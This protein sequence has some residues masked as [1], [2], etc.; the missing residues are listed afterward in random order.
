MK[1]LKRKVI[2]LVGVIAWFWL[3][4]SFAVDIRQLKTD[5]SNMIQHFEKIK[6]VSSENQTAN[7][8][9]QYVWWGLL[10]IDTDNII[11]SNIINTTPVKIGGWKWSSIL[12]GIVNEIE[13]NVY[14]VI[15][16][17]ENNSISTNYSTIIWWRE[18]TVD[19][20]QYGTILWW[21]ENVLKGNF[22]TIVWGSNNE[23]I[24]EKSVSLWKNG[25]VS[26]NNSVWIWSDFEV[27][28]KNSFVW[29]AGVDNIE[30]GENV[31]VVNGGNGMVINTGKAYS[32]AKLTV[33]W[34]MIIG[35]NNISFTSLKCS[36]DTRWALIIKKNDAWVRCFCTCNGEERNSIIWWQC[37]WVCSKKIVPECG[38]EVHK[39]VGS[40]PPYS[41]S[42]S[43]EKWEVVEW[44]WAYVVWKNDI[45]YWSCQSVDWVVT[46]CAWVLPEEERLTWDDRSFEC[47][48]KMS[49]REGVITWWGAPSNGATWY[50]HDESLTKPCSYKC[51]EVWYVHYDWACK[52]KAKG[53][54]N[55]DVKWWCESWHPGNQDE[56]IIDR[57]QWD[58]LGFWM[59]DAFWCRKCKE[60]Y[61]LSGDDCV[62]RATFRE[63][64]GDY[65]KIIAGGKKIEVFAE[66][67]PMY[68]WEYTYNISDD[69][70]IMIEAW[71]HEPDKAVYYMLRDVDEIYLPKN[72]SNM[73]ASMKDLERI[74]VE[75]D[76]NTSKVMNM[77]NMFAG[78]SQLESVDVSNWDTSNVTNMSNMFKNCSS[79][80]ELDLSSWNTS[81]VT[82]MES[83][84]K[85]CSSLTELDLSSWN[86]SNV[87]NMYNMFNDCNNLI[88]IYGSCW[89]KTSAIAD[90]VTMFKNC[91]NL[92]WWW[93]TTY[94]S[95]SCSSN[96][97]HT[98][99]D[100]Y[101]AR[102]DIQWQKWY[103]T[104]KASCG[105]GYQ[106]EG[107]S[108]KECAEWFFSEGWGCCIAC[109]SQPLSDDQ[110]VVINGGQKRI[111]SK[112]NCEMVSNTN[113]DGCVIGCKSWYHWKVRE[114]YTTTEEVCEGLI[115]GAGCYSLLFGLP[116]SCWDENVYH[117]AEA[118]CERD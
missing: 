96:C 115:P 79:L 87:T 61:T 86:T 113:K 28:G 99:Y 17:W 57:Y 90:S 94:A 23:V 33:G 111:T 52:K 71:Y 72:S 97:D 24:G 21:R 22:S 53:V 7:A 32:F 36:R 117:E 55:N 85:S 77:S 41:Y 84:F 110:Y 69:P 103:L 58:C 83:M 48:G 20:W 50:V 70:N 88:T 18:N 101:Y 9:I 98:Q 80:T 82:N 35:D 65:L 31:F 34:P 64:L 106:E 81:N 38:S 25:V 56:S 73:F 15:V 108:C 114:A 27:K 11:I 109:S 39:I 29:N 1:N 100:A 2:W 105:A 42:W 89:F 6:I 59:D 74:E 13:N 40:E 3:M 8:K 91:S 46:P 104:S 45:I 112:D 44:T 37:A 5:L 102:L 95:V 75:K 116:C 66:N 19:K 12:W 30:V 92:V 62:K 43:C 63:N 4:F 107:G 60:W 93:W 76:W 49:S 26:W 54:C 67:G 78:D 14:S 16:W 10:G 47:W 68:M 118:W 51:D